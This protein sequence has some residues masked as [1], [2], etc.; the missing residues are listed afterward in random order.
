MAYFEFRQKNIFA[1]VFASLTLAFLCSCNPL[2]ETKIGSEF[3]PS[4]GASTQYSTVSVSGATVSAASSVTVTLSVRDQNSQPF[5]SDRT[6]VAFA[7]SG[8]TSAGS[9]GPVTNNGDG[10]YS[11]VFTGLT[12]GTA[13]RISAT[14]N[15][16]ALTSIL[17]SLTVLPGNFSLSNSILSVSSSTVVSGSVVTL[18][19]ATFD[20]SNN[21]ITSGGLAVTFSRSGGTSTGVVSATTDH[22]DGTYSATFTGQSAGTATS[23][24]ATIGGTSVTSSSPTISVTPGAPASIGV[25]SGGGQTG[26]VGSLLT[27]FV[28]IVRDSNSNIVSGVTVDWTVMAGGGSLSSSSSATDAGGLSSS[29]LT[30]GPSP[31]VNSVSASIN[32][33]AISVGFSA[34]GAWDADAQIYFDRVSTAGGSISAGEQ[35]NINSFVVGLKNLGLFSYVNDAWF[36]RSSQNR[37]SGSVLYGLKALSDGNLVSS[38]TW[39]AD[40]ITSPGTGNPPPHIQ[41]PNTARTNYAQRTVMI[42]FFRT[43]ASADDAYCQTVNY[44]QFYPGSGEGFKLD[45]QIRW[46]ASGAYVDI[47]QPVSNGTQTVLTTSYNAGTVASY[48]NGGN[49]ISNSIGSLTLTDTQSIRLMAMQGGSMGDRGLNGRMTFVIDFTIQ[50]VDT[51]V[52]SVYA[53]YK[54]TVGQGLSLP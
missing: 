28:A 54:N 21:A 44:S 10:T 24:F 35:S 5:V 3:F 45:A 41:L 48:K 37:G 11:A 6:S 2:S 20:T 51:E 8:G 1:F 9:F 43:A 46:G 47:S 36:L 26:L 18:R 22:G 12:A 38:P 52:A 53:L 14:L 39:G 33:T 23:I 4:I 40:G 30:L 7:A 34:T 27:A 32:G 13:T 16:R 49:K 25:S 50:L 42:S 15:G 17:P 29:A 19:L 31:G